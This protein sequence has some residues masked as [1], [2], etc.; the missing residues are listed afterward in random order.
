[1]EEVDDPVEEDDEKASGLKENPAG[2]ISKLH[3]SE[4]PCS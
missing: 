3:P 4:F 2:T 1:V